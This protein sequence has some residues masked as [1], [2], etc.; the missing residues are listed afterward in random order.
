MATV[1][2]LNLNLRFS[3]IPPSAAAVFLR[4]LSVLLALEP[5]ATLIFE[6]DP[7]AAF[8][9]AIFYLGISIFFLRINLNFKNSYSLF[10]LQY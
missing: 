8:F 4:A 1:P 2:G 5:V 7:L 9:P 6:T 10:D 3:L